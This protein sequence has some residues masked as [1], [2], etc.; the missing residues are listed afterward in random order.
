ME[1]A[2]AEPPVPG[3]LLCEGERFSWAGLLG[4]RKGITFYHHK[5]RPGG[6]RG[7]VVSGALAGK[8]R[9]GRDPAHGR[10]SEG[11]SGNTGL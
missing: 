4:Y 3:K 11:P 2:A 7:P 9:D 8:S 5:N 10:L 6:H 1:R